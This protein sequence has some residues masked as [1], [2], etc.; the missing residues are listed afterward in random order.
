MMLLKDERFHFSIAFISYTFRTCNRQ[1]QTKSAAPCKW[2]SP[3]I[4]AAVT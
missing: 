4:L 3:K 2:R 1:T